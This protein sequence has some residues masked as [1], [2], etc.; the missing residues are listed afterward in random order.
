M[1]AFSSCGLLVTCGL[2]LLGCSTVAQPPVKIEVPPPVSPTIT[3]SPMASPQ[4]LPVTAQLLLGSRKILLEVAATA[5]EQT[6]GLMYRTS[7]PNDRGMLFTFAQPGPA[8]F[9]MKNTLIPL[10][11][12]FLRSGQIQNIQADVPPCKA[13]PCQNY[14][15]ENTVLIDQVLELNAGQAKALGLKVGDRLNIQSLPK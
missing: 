5:Q 7:M 4:N 9:W 15:P 13:D 14:G 11:I 6:I 2:L 1:F 10:D 3:V 8:K 12:L